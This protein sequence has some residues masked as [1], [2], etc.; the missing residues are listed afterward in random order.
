MPYDLPDDHRILRA[1]DEAE[2]Y[3]LLELLDDSMDSLSTIEKSGKAP[4][5]A[6]LMRARIHQARGEQGPAAL[7]FEEARERLPDSIEPRIGLGWSYKRLGRLPDAIRVLAEGRRRFPR[8][9]L[10]AYNLACYLALAERAPEAL[11]ELAAAIG[12]KASYRELARHDDD[13]API[14]DREEFRRLVEE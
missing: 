8:E 2:G 12:M 3:F 14:R 6:A 9:A 11:G 4:G 5:F 13:F 1:A 7:A 10:F